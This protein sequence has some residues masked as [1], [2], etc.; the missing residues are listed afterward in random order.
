M[1]TIFTIIIIGISLSMD[2]FSLSLI[3]G[4]QGISKKNEIILSIIVGVF[5]FFMPLLGCFFGN[6]IFK[7][8][9]FNINLLISIIFGL[10]GID[11]IISGVKKEET[12]LLSGI[13]GYLMFG[14]SV[15]IDSFSTGIGLAGI[16]DNYL[17][18]SLIFMLCSGLF[19]FLGLKLGNV[20]NSKMGCYAN[21][22]GGIIFIFL[23]LY[24]L[25]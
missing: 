24:F 21:I 11:M 18:V 5:H 14:F 25:F 3:Y 8:F 13:L 17:L 7:C 16:S 20:F 23:V 10:I 2:A 22:M 15:S 9:E 19:T 4:A 12:S 1:S 6:I